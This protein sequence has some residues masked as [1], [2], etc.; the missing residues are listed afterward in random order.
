[1]LVFQDTYFIHIWFISI[2][3]KANNTTAHFWA[4]II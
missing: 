4:K 2:E 3:L 1:M